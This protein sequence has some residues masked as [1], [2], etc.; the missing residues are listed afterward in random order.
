MTVIREDVR[1]EAEHDGLWSARVTSTSPLCARPIQ[2]EASRCRLQLQHARRR[3][4][5][6]KN[7]RQQK[8]AQNRVHEGPTVAW[9][10]PAI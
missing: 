3:D 10:G 1:D 9:I 7:C 8:H 5:V 4:K 6:N 2:N